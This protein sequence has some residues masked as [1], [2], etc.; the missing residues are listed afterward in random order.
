MD[1]LMGSIQVQY[2]ETDHFHSLFSFSF[3]FSFPICRFESIDISALQNQLHFFLRRNIANSDILYE[4][5]CH[6]SEFELYYIPVCELLFIEL[7]ASDLSLYGLQSCSKA[8][9]LPYIYPFWD[10]VDTEST[11][12]VTVDGLLSDF[13]KSEKLAVTF[14]LCLLYIHTKA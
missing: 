12:L 9:Y 7:L 4:K 5:D 11:G 1:I 6:I 10:R 2:F 8:E 14:Y 3:S 13:R